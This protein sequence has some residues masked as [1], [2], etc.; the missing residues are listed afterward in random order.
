[1]P[2]RIYLVGEWKNNAD[3]WSCRAKS[4]RIVLSYSGKVR[5]HCGRRTAESCT[6][7][8]DGSD[9]TGDGPRSDVSETGHSLAIDGQR[10]Y[11][12]AIHDEYG[13]TDYRDYGIGEG[14][15]IYTFT[16]G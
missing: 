1:M 13:I 12:I 5:Q 2:N 7:R 10:L 9:L 4:A 14:F 16:F 8:E 11:N 6:Y 3:Q 15:E